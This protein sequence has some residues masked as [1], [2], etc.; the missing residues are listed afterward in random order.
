MVVLEGTVGCVGCP[1][2]GLLR[3]QAVLACFRVLCACLVAPASEQLR[4]VF[5][6]GEF[7]TGVK[8]KSGWPL[9]GKK[10]KPG[11]S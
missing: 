4:L 6:G 5:P 3:A 2:L 7:W 9:Q 8:G 11:P 1:S 10:T